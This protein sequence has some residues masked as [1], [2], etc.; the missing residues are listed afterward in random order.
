MVQHIHKKV[1][2]H[3]MVLKLDMM[4]AFDR[5]SWVFLRQLLL[6]FGFHPS[7]V[8]IIMGNFSAS[9]FSVSINGSPSGFFQATRGLKQGDPLSP[10]LFIL[11]VES[12]G[13]GLKSL[14]HDGQL[15][16]YSLPRNAPSFSHLCFADDLVIFL[17]GQRRTVRSLLVFL[18]L[19]E[20]ATGQTINRTKSSFLISK[21]CSLSQ[22]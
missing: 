7:F 2:G 21:H 12:L 13:R 19:Y 11:V 22:V 17:R 4:K 20:L 14:L 5:V 1:K 3:N 15:V 16:P 8:Q 18:G 10:Y 6:K 9:W